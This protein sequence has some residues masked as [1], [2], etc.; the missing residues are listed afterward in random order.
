[1][2][3]QIIGIKRKKDVE[4]EAL[5]RETN[6]SAELLKPEPPKLEPPKRDNNQPLDPGKLSLPKPTRLEGIEKPRKPVK[7]KIKAPIEV[8]EVEVGGEMFNPGELIWVTSPFGTKAKG[9]ILGFYQD[10]GETWARFVPKELP[11]E[12]LW[13]SGY[14]RSELLVKIGP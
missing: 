11:E 10:S 1:M 5:T 2:P 9:E 8:P 14:I 6:S 7:P 12:S 13:E 4:A 3:N